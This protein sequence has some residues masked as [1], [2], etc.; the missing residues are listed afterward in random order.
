MGHGLA[1]GERI[2]DGEHHVADLER[3]RIGK[4]ERGKALLLRLDAQHRE[5]GARILEHHFGLELAFVGERHLDLVGAL[6]DVVVGHHK[7]GGV[8]EHPRAE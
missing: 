7:A 2:A 4:F 1:H 8:D 3:V 5:V 6:D